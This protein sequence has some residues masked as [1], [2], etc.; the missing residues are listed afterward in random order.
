M[1]PVHY[2]LP[3]IIATALA[4]AAPARAQSVI[5]E[6]ENVKAPPPPTLKPVTVDAKT[7]A[8][9]V[10]DMTNQ[11][12]GPQRYARCPE[13]VPAVKK[14]LAEA[15]AKEATV[16]FTSIPNVGKS[17]IIKDLEPSANEHFVQSFLDK[18]L[19]SDLE[20]TLRAKGV[21]TIIITGLAANGAVLYTSSEAA[22]KGFSIVVPVDATTA[23]SPYA[24]QFSVW[25][26]GNA[27]VI[28]A[29]ITLTKSDMI[30]F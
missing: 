5:A 24:E 4:F 9:V 26:L 7:T 13:M 6:W 23:M 12:C 29:K 8:L 25:Q 19:N 18:F 16:V 15:R 28:S 30:K 21:T 1:V 27:P 22:Q 20:K 10:L 11:F 3:A 2:L 17:E 14:L